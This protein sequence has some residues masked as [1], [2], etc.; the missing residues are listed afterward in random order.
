MILDHDMMS[1]YR[2]EFSQISKLFI[3][4]GRNS[5]FPIEKLTISVFLYQNLCDNQLNLRT[6]TSAKQFFSQKKFESK[7]EQ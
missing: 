6:S 2:N 7:R 5:S 1:Q 4:N 3:D